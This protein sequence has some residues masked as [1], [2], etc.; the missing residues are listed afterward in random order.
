MALIKNPDIPVLHGTAADDLFDAGTASM[1][2][3]LFGGLGNDVYWVSGDVDP[4]II[5]NAGE[6][7]DT[8]VIDG[9]AV[10]SPYLL[11]ANVENL[12]VR[13][14]DHSGVY[15]G[16]GLA[17]QI[18]MVGAAAADSDETLDGGAGNDTLAGGFGDDTYKVDSAGDVVVENAGAGLDRVQS[19]A[20][21]YT[22]AANVEILELL[23]GAG[24]GAGNALDNEILG[25]DGHNSLDGGLGND[26]LAGGNGNDTLLGGSGDDSLDGGAGTDNLQGGVGNDVYF[27]DSAGDVVTEQA[28]GGF[29]TVRLGNGIGAHTLAA[30]VEDLYLA[31]EGIA[32]PGKTGTGNALDNMIM[33]TAFADLIDG[34]AGNDVI[35]GAGGADTLKGGLGNDVFVVDDADVQVVENA[36]E[37]VD[38]VLSTVDYRLTAN[39]EQLV[40]AGAAY[41]GSGNAL[42]NLLQGNAQ[43]NLLSGGGGNDTLNGGAG[44]D[45]LFGGAGNDTYYYDGSDGIY[46]RYGSTPTDQGIDTVL[47]T[48]HVGALFMNVENL[49]LLG[50]ADLVGYGNALSNS[51]TG[52][53]G[54]NTLSGG[55]G[56]DTL[57]GGAGNDTYYIDNLD[58]PVAE[59]AGAGVDTVVLWDYSFTSSYVLAANVENLR[60]ESGQGQMNATGNLLDNVITGNAAANTLT[61]EAGNDTLLAGAG[62]DSLEGGL[63]NDILNGQAG[64]DTMKGGAGDDTYYV[65]SVHDVVDER[66]TSG[67]AGVDTVISNLRTTDLG[68]TSV[69]L[70]V[71]TTDVIENI[72]LESSA[73]DAVGNSLANVIRGNLGANLLTGKGGNDTYY[74]DLR[75]SVVEDATPTAGVDTVI[76]DVADAN[77]AADLGIIMLDMASR[78]ANVE[79]LTLLGTGRYGITGTAAA[80]ILIGNDGDNRLRGMA[81]N[82]T[83][84]GGKGNDVYQVDNLGDKVTENLDEG[85]DWVF[86]QVAYTLGANL[87]HLVLTG[88]GNL[89]G[90][91]NALANRIEGGAGNNALSGLDGN[92][93][94]FGFVGADTLLGGNGDDSLDGGVGNDTLDGGAGNDTLL[95]GAGDSLAGGAGDDLYVIGA[96]PAALTEAAGGGNDILEITAGAAFPTGFVLANTVFVETLRA[97]AGAGAVKITGNTQN[98]TLV[99]GAGNDTLAGGGGNDVF[100]GSLGGNDSMTGGAGNDRFDFNVHFSLSD[101]DVIDG[102]GQGPGGADVLNANVFDVTLAIDATGIEV[103]NFSLDVVELDFTGI[104]TTA[105]TVVNVT[106]NDA[107]FTHLGAGDDPLPK[108]VL[109][110]YENGGILTTNVSLDDASGL[111]DRVAFDLDRVDAEMSF[112]GIETLRLNVIGTPLGGNNLIELGTVTGLNQVELTG[113]GRLELG[114]LAGGSQAVLLDAYMGRADLTL[115]DASG[116]SDVL[117]IQTDD[118]QAAIYTTGIETL[119]IEALNGMPS[120]LHL[121]GSDADT[122]TLLGQAGESQAGDLLI[123]SLVAATVDATDFDGTFLRLVSTGDAVNT[124]FSFGKAGVTATVYGNAGD[125]S[126]GFVLDGDL[127]TLTTEDYVDGG[128]GSDTLTAAIDGLTATESG[129][130]RLAGV[131]HVVLSNNSSGDYIAETHTLGAVGAGIDAAL[132]GNYAM[133]DGELTLTGNAIKIDVDTIAEMSD[134]AG[135]R[136]GQ[137]DTVIYN[138]GRDLD[139]TGYSGD[140][141]L[142]SANTGGGHEFKFGEGNHNVIGASA[143]GISDVFKFGS[144]AFDR[145]DYVE[146]FDSGYGGVFNDGDKLYATLT[147]L[148]AISGALRIHG[149]ETLYLEL[150]GRNIV[151]AEDMDGVRWIELK[152]DVSGEGTSAVA[153]TMFGQNDTASEGIA[154]AADGNGTEIHGESL[155]VDLHLTGGYGDDHYFA[156]SGNDTLI[157]AGGNDT[158]EGGAGTNVLEGG[159]GNDRLVG[160]ADDDNLKGEEGND[161][162]VAGDG[163]DTLTGGAG[164]D[165]ADYSGADGPVHLTIGDDAVQADVVNDDGEDGI[166]SFD[167]VLYGIERLVGT[168]G[169]DSLTVAFSANFQATAGL[170]GYNNQ[171]NGSPLADAFYNLLGGN[172]TDVLTGPS[173]ING[174]FVMADYSTSPGAAHAFLGSGI[175]TVGGVGLTGGAADDGFGATDTLSNIDGL[176]GSSH[177]DI[178][179]G[180][181]QSRN[182]VGTLFESYIGGEGND[183]IAGSG[184]AVDHSLDDSISG[185]PMDVWDFDRADYSL[186]PSRILVNLA[187][188]TVRDGWGDTDHLYG[189]NLIR[190]SSFADQIFGS[191]TFGSAQDFQ[192]YEGMAGD[193]VIDGGGGLDRADYRFSPNAVNVNLATG[194]AEDGWGTRDALSGIDWVMASDF[195]DTLTGGAGN[196]WFTGMAGNDTMD[197]GLGTDRADYRNE[198]DADY[199]GDG[200]IVNLSAASFTTAGGW[201]GGGAATVAAGKALDG[202]GYVD[203]LLNM[204]NVRGSVYNDLIIGSAGNNFI[205]AQGGNDTLIGGGGADIFV[206]NTGP[207]GATNVDTI[208]DFT[209]ASDKLHFDNAVFTAIGADGAFTAANFVSG[210]GAA[211]ALDAADRLI[212]NTTTGDLYYDADGT[213]ATAAVK[214]AVLTGH[215]TLAATDIQVV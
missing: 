113:G 72:T 156:G 26:D 82:D 79:H 112:T 61:G 99:G 70:R 84:A 42:D 139:A 147:G 63:G 201:N 75:D 53:A 185:F 76:L 184:G 106:G 158:L 92:D 105:S 83:M 56:N 47:S 3:A 66:A 103:F 68:N 166:D 142:L 93:S 1:D 141:F 132:M 80:N 87:E 172:G 96:A 114:G 121:A 37:G 145:L 199:N 86:S 182:V 22:L 85:T 102:G 43:A 95:G 64:G 7:T 108:L 90:T 88:P 21:S 41:E 211:A 197:G 73:V 31:D 130:L 39:V 146:G 65:Y 44:A 127:A 159:Y 176:R 71:G 133:G 163:L 181:S 94:L 49:V 14:T 48:A 148:D 131:E 213:G 164:S 27:L 52:N 203:T 215:P 24:N 58:A 170:K 107:S 81:G 33:G 19:T 207:N 175:I 98:N 104:H 119:E 125:D 40:L 196:D 157:G 209:T 30:N 210:A 137:Y 134:P 171:G 115:A 155:S 183:T 212:Y 187:A 36:G 45:V 140:I 59:A 25:N 186:D 120:G 214:V 195:A 91:G 89:A 17:N 153:F 129:A 204:E 206:F 162:L 11:A 192:A 193:D 189:I 15:Q 198:F 126:F 122:L 143:T 57:A 34:G 160:G 117:R 29:D 109:R 6:G 18:T 50:T 9:V 167:D 51:I 149:V 46:E 4:A 128:S 62:N 194:I 16:N 205:D 28:G 100:D 8:I 32:G 13:V 178:L 35:H 150:D 135:T 38:R 151:N 78:Y 177:D 60:I 180:G 173:A 118:A 188:G 154:L 179:V 200:V 174:V 69:F 20:A 110:D 5:E 208:A 101:G 77:A 67:G 190:G 168:T 152:D 136:T 97:G 165:T 161:V 55:V 124:A 169:S 10:D 191:D 138:L 116:G 23:A 123:R 144:S 111:S 74:V 12:T 202:W 54:H 2:Q